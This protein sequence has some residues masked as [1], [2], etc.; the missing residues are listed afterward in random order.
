MLLAYND[1]KYGVLICL[2]KSKV[3]QIIRSLERQ[4]HARQLGL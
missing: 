4:N 3:I 1:Y 2:L